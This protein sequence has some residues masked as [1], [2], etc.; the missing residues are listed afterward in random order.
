MSDAPPPPPPHDALTTRGLFERIARDHPGTLPLGELLDAF[1]ERAFGLFLLVAVLPAFLP[2]PAGA[3]AVSGPLVALAGVQLL[4][5]AEHPWLPR[6]LQRRPVATASIEALQARLAKPL[7]W[8]ERVSH[9]RWQA[10]IDHPAAKAVTGLL[11]LVLGLVLA[12][13]IPLTNYPF[14]LILVLYAVALIERDGLSMAIAWGLG[15][16]Q[17]V[18]LGFFAGDVAKA[19]VA[20]GEHI[21]RW[22]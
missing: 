1:S 21:A 22:I 20:L 9:P 11:L 18:L 4:L 5:Q 12:L 14:G 15:L 17:L 2:L 7:A 3:G 13:P 16:G 19:I 8:L 10:M 6:W